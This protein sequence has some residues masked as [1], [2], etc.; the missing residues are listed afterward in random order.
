M[1]L[2]CLTICK[3][4][5][6]W[7]RRL[8]LFLTILYLVCRRKHFSIKSFFF[9]AVAQF[10]VFSP[11]YRQARLH[12][13]LG[14]SLQIFP[15]ANLPFPTRSTK[16]PPYCSPS[17][18]SLTHRFPERRL[19]ENFI[20][21]TVTA[22]DDSPGTSTPPSTTGTDNSGWCSLKT[23]HEPKRQKLNIAVTDVAPKTVIV[24]LQPT[25]MDSRA[26]MCLRAEID[27]VLVRVC[28]N[29]GVII[30]KIETIGKTFIPQIVLR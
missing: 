24:N 26:D 5:F 28:E 22:E 3:V 1:L 14:T 6:H 4:P 20:D 16:L 30:P 13:C 10:T 8:S 15:A 12:L 18:S 11:S 19:K 2:I 7:M 23:K 27:R 21:L 29:L 25:K 17:D 9:R